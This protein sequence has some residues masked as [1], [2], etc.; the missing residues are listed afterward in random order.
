MSEVSGYSIIDKKE[1]EQDC[2]YTPK[3]L[4]KDNENSNYRETATSTKLNSS[5]QNSQKCNTCNMCITSQDQDNKPLV[6]KQADDNEKLNIINKQADSRKYDAERKTMLKNSVYSA[7]V[8]L[9]LSLVSKVVTFFFNVLLLREVNKEFYGIAKV[10]FEFI[11]SLLVFFPKETVRRAC[12]KFSSEVTSDEEE[13]NRLED[14]TRL[15][16]LVNYLTYFLSVVVFYC[17]VYFAPTLENYKLHLMLYVLSANLELLVEPI[18]LYINLRIDTN[19]KFFSSTIINYSKAILTYYFM[20]WGYGIAAFTI[21]RVISCLLFCGFLLL[22]GYFKYP[23]FRRLIWPV[24]SYQ[25]LLDINKDLIG[26]FMGNFKVSSLKMILIYTERFVLSFFLDLSEEQKGEYSFIVDNFTIL[27]KCFL[28]PAEEIF[29]N[30]ISKVKNNF[31]DRLCEESNPNSMRDIADNTFEDFEYKFK[32]LNLF[33]DLKQ[34]PKISKKGSCDTS[35]NQTDPSVHSKLLKIAVRFMMIFGIL[36]TAY[37]LIVGKEVIT[38]V[39]TEKW[40]TLSVIRLTKMYALYITLMAINVVMEGYLNAIYPTEK[41][42]A[43]LFFMICNSFLLI[44]LSIYLTINDSAG[45]IM[46]NALALSFRIIV[47]LY[48]ILSESKLIQKI[49][50]NSLSWYDILTEIVQ[51]FQKAFINKL[52]WFSVIICL[53]IIRFIQHKSQEDSD[54]FIIICTGVVLSFNVLIIWLLEKNNFQKV[55]EEMDSS[56]EV[57]SESL[58]KNPL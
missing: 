35:S 46:A 45:L 17:F 57:E 12:Q 33:N 13:L 14:C 39:F 44:F 41:I 30:I 1:S 28:E 24:C 55:L 32:N 20:V 48:F 8:F 2:H 42:G 29:Y 56:N 11:F 27:I 49:K 16:W 25:N 4:I 51:F 7:T 21:A 5:F 40:A 15:C 47:N 37:L 22:V 38:I 36:L 3:A 19:I 26:Y 9:I 53:G 34:S 31:Q 6:F 10:Y 43:Y 18:M 52:S 50:S 54:F 58:T 23:N